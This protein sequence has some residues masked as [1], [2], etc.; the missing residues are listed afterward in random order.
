MSTIFYFLFL[1]LFFLPIKAAF[2]PLHGEITA[3]GDHYPAREH[4]TVGLKLQMNA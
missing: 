1:F 3:G 4:I 2:L